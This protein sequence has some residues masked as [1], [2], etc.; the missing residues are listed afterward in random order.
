MNDQIQDIDSITR[1]PLIPGYSKFNTNETNL[2]KSNQV[3]AETISNREI[4]IG[5]GTITNLYEP[6]DQKD[7]A[8][9][10]YVD[11]INFINFEQVNINDLTGIT[12][13]V[14]NIIKGYINRNAENS[15]NTSIVDTYPSINEIINYL[16]NTDSGAYVGYTINT[17]L[18]NVSSF[19]K[20]YS[21]DIFDNWKGISYSDSDL[22]NYI[23]IIFT[24]KSY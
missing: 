10:K 23:D 15:T 1:P 24:K 8:T 22:T 9:K 21:Y 16:N 2:L 17:L 7:I 3:I 5:N 20:N 19:S 18:K 13:S 12:Y 4:I 14:D 11:N 6:V